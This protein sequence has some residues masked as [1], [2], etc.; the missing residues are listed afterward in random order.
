MTSAIFLPL[1]PASNFPFLTSTPRAP[2]RFGSFRRSTGSTTRIST[3]R[4]RTSIGPAAVTRLGYIS[5]AK[6]SENVGNGNHR[7]KGKIG[8]SSENA[9]VRMH[10]SHVES[11]LLF[12]YF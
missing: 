11:V 6:R 2:G 1:S 10:P 3:S 7:V 5:S 4:A 8:V 9:R 12:L